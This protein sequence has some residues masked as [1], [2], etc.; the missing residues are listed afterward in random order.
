MIRRADTLLR[1]PAS[2]IAALAIAQIAGWTLAPALTHVAPPLDV[3]EGYMWGQEWV[4]ASYKHPALPSWVLEI[5][6]L[7]TGTVGWPAYLIA[8]LFIAATF[9]LVFALGRDLMGPA[10][11]AAGT[12]L[13][14]GI[15]FYSWPTP[16]FNHSIAQL[17][18]LAGV[19]WSVWRAV[20]RR[21]VLWWAL[22]GAFAAGGLYAKL[23]AAL[24]LV[25]AAGWIVADARARR[26][27]ATPGPWVGLAVF[28]A[29]IAPLALWMFGHGFAQIDYVAQRAHYTKP[30]GV[31]RFILSGLATLLPMVAMLA[32]C[33][34]LP[35]R[36]SR[37]D[38]VA[39]E[40]DRRA[41]FYLLALNAGPPVLAVCATLFTGSGLRAAWTNSMF[42]L[43]GLLAV[44]LCA[45]RF[46][47]EALRR[48]AVGAAVLVT[49]VPIG[50]AVTAGLVPRGSRPPLRVQWPQAEI[51]ERMAAIWARQT[52]APLRIVAGENW[53]AGLIGLS[54]KDHP[55]LLSNA[56]VEYSPWISP[57]RLRKQ[58][59]LVVWDHDK[60]PIELQPFLASPGLPAAR[61]ERFKS[62]YSEREILIGYLIIPPKPV[63]P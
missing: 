31:L 47:D 9:A 3:V 63:S 17:P 8:Q 16:E 34:L 45:S 23:S 46:T 56:D 35:W 44:A 27:L 48:I 18:F 6:R 25:T 4:I 40:V 19:A 62:R 59:M 20:E 60:T 28:A 54:H 50:Y 51:A 26:S 32:I 37:A 52:Q 61:L 12:L 38:A 29:L 24:L 10:R 2:L 1:D 49:V 58:G 15:F 30:H 22:T 39:P 33:G 13:L 21:S 11:A 14:T 57:D 55:S 42:N 53:I 36:Q 7:V 43:V 41:L 5:S